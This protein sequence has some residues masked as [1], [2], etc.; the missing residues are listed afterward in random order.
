MVPYCSKEMLR[1]FGGSK[2]S[3]CVLPR[4]L[5]LE[6]LHTIINYV[7]FHSLPGRSDKASLCM[8]DTG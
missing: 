8:E 2:H 4:Q 1:G 3:P 7:E 6:T 5:T